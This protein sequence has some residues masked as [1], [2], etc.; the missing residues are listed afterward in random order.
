MDHIIS[1]ILTDGASIPCS[2][3]RSYCGCTGVARE[4]WLA[5]SDIWIAE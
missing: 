5:G 4:H 3:Q 2:S 1:T